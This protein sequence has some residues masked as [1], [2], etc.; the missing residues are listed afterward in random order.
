MLSASRPTFV[1][2]IIITERKTQMK[3]LLKIPFSASLRNRIHH[4]P[5]TNNPKLPLPNPSNLCPNSHS[6]T[7]LKWISSFSPLPPPEWVQPTTD[8]SDVVTADSKKDLRPSPWVL[9]ILN[10]L[11]KNTNLEQEL[12]EYCRKYLIKLPPSFVAYIL[13]KSDHIAKQPETAYRFLTW[14]S[15]QR[16]YTHSLECYVFMIEILSLARDLDRI[17]FVFNEFK[18]KGF[19]LN[20]IVANSLIRSFGSVGM[21]EELLWVWKMMKENEIE[22]SLCTYNCLM[23]GLVSSEFVESA[24]RVF[25]VMENGKIKPDVVTYNTIIKGYCKAGRVKKA[26]ERFQDM[27][28][29]NVEPDKITYMTLMQACYSQEDYDCCLRLYH[30][31]KEKGLDIPPHAYSLV[32]SGLCKDGKSMEG[33]S[34][35]ENMIQNECRPNIAIYTALIDAYAK[36]QNLDIAMGLFQRMQSEGFEPDE[37]TY[38]VIVNGLCKSG[39]LENALQ[40]FQYCRSNN[41]SINTVFYSSLIDGLGKAGRIDEAEKLFEEMVEKGCPRDSYCYNV[42]IDALAKS[43]QVDEALTLFKR[44]EDE[45]CDQT[46]YT[47]TILLSGLFKEHRNEE[48]LKLWDMMIDKGITPNDASFRVLSTG[49]CLSGKVARACKI[50]DELAPMGIVVETAFQHMICVLCKAGR[51]AEACKLAD[52]VVER[53]RE[54]PGK[55][56]TIMINALRKAGNADL[57]MKLMHS[58]IG[59]G[60]DRL[61]SVKR[62]VKF[63]NLVEN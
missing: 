41:V 19:L 40:W 10:I 44:M 45:G 6:I 26:M 8:L 62:R 36:N 57:A 15:K 18:R 29:K 27:E 9:Q 48:A 1:P 37:I 38:G 35:F 58:K 31:M 2:A 7:L 51:I 42:F 17:K 22:P 55:V 28:L 43:G 46:V 54:I 5:F 33:Y 4:C 30:E 56:R 63:R 20:S 21:V 14:A 32:I 3:K 34:V 53:G 61:G 11:H 24:E 13:K 12:T 25:E 50:L 59:I 49:L 16:G 47:Y 60:Y 52:G 23:N 39:R